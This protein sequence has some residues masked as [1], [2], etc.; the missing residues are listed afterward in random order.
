MRAR[1]RLVS[2]SPRGSPAIV[3]FRSSRS[4]PTSLAFPPHHL[5]PAFPPPPAFHD[6]APPHLHRQPGLPAP[7]PFSPSMLFPHSIPLRGA[8]RSRG[9]KQGRSGKGAKRERGKGRE[10]ER[11]HLPL[12]PSPLTRSAS[13][14]WYFAGRFLPQFR[15]RAPLFFRRTG[16]I[17]RA[18]FSPAKSRL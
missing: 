9:G 17:S 1:H 16:W 11:R 18:C 4:L 5:H 10:R 7:R 15:L 2:R 8:G 12:H 3:S 14:R 6:L 13:P